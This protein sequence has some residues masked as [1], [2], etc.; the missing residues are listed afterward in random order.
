MSWF[1]SLT[2]KAE[3]FLNQL[4]EAAATSL[5]DSGLV[6]PSPKKIP[7]VQTQPESG[8][9][10]EPVAQPNPKMTTPP[11]RR[12]QPVIS[13]M[14]H[15]PSHPLGMTPPTESTWGSSWSVPFQS[16]KVTE[17]PIKSS[18]SGRGHVTED[19]LLEYL[20]TPS[21]KDKQK[22]VA[23]TVKTTPLRPHSADKTTAERSSEKMEQY[24]GNR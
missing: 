13:S 20:N 7:S 22:G 19:S 6:T 17:D 8:L 3:A 14:T 5:N 16:T 23:N 24:T 12:S 1:S 15:K 11:P 9:T 2:G 18:S 21:K 4:D 10:Y